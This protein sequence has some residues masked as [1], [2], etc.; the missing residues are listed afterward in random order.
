MVMRLS[1]S[2][3]VHMIC[4]YLKEPYAHEHDPSSCIHATLFLCLIKITAST[5]Y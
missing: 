2:E 1:T 3:Q 5:T 4:I